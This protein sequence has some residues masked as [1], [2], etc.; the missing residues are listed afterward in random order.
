MRRFALIGNPLS[1]SFSKAFFTR[2]FDE[3]NLADDCNYENHE[4]NHPAQL[5]DLI[6]SDP[7]LV[8]INVTSPFKESI[9]PFLN[10]VVGVASEIRSVNTIKIIRNTRGKIRHTIGFNTDVTGFEQ[11]I[12]KH[13]TPN[14]RGALILGTGGSSKAVYWVLKQLGMEV[15]F[16]SRETGKG[17]SYSSVNRQM[18]SEFPLIINTTPLGTYPEVDAAPE[19]PYDQL[20]ENNLLFDLVYNPSETRFLRLGKNQGATTVGGYEM[21]TFQA[22]ES[23]KI[24]NTR[25]DYES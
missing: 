11:A 8:G 5:H 6:Q 21:L 15:R 13:L 10:K 12:K 17:I 9:I 3:Q 25:T 4:L 14:H 2:F 1:H 7:C 22:I 23:W 20:T 19:L 24:W 18:L 16:L